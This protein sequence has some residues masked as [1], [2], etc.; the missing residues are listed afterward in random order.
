M[1]LQCSNPQC[2]IP[3]DFRQG[4]IFRFF[5]DRTSRQA[6]PKA[7]GVRHFWLCAKCSKTHILEYCGDKIVLLLRNFEPLMP[8]F[9][10]DDSVAEAS[11]AP[12]SQAPARR[13]RAHARRSPARTRSSKHYSSERTPLPSLA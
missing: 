1:L 11:Q 8:R 7:H 3:F 10:A 12:T 2:N 5:S 4:R 13:K 9:L 6:S